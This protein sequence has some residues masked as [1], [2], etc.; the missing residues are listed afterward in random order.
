MARA[1]AAPAAAAIDEAVATGRGARDDAARAVECQ[2][3]E[4]SVARALPQRRGVRL[5]QRRE[6]LDEGRR[7]HR[8]RRREAPA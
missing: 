8:A 3:G 6:T 2:V 7:R 1:S 5:P 4:H